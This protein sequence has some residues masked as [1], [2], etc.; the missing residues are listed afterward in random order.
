MQL[1][2]SCGP[3]A[4]QIHGISG[5]GGRELNN[6]NSF[7]GSSGRKKSREA[8]QDRMWEESNLEFRDLMGSCFH[9]PVQQCQN[10]GKEGPSEVNDLRLIV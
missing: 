2:H 5:Q 7:C 9:K 10:G 4:I 3:H 6:R 8:L 1:A